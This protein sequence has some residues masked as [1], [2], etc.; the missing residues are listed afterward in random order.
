MVLNKQSLADQIYHEI[1]DLIINVEVE[2]GEKIDVS[3]L[4]EKYEVSRAPI[5]E[6]L[7]RLANQ[8]LVEVR[9]RVGYFAVE[10]L[11]NQVRDICELRKLFET[12]ALQQ[13]VE[14]VDKDDL[15]ELL[16]E[17]LEL[18]HDGLDPKELRFRFD[19]TDERLHKLIITHAD[20]EL[21]EEFT[22][23]IHNLIG[24]TRHL[25]ERIQEAIDE[26]V[27]LLRAMI[28]RNSERAKKALSKHLDNVEE[29]ILRSINSG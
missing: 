9:P 15:K 14:E 12:Y 22:E 7:N 26:H 13:S 17:S 29:E 27:I 16:E 4:E 6:A 24:L 28:N 20:N 25:N 19:Q 18:K 1:R 10:L 2:P 11:P 23:R 3:V 5:R 21:L 8:G